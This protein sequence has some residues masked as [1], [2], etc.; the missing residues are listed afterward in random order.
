ME[1][2]N[3]L[4]TETFGKHK[5]DRQIMYTITIGGE[6]YFIGEYS[7]TKGTH[8]RGAPMLNV[9][10]SSAEVYGSRTHQGLR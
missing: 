3:A 9:S 8:E 5:Y 6:K 4:S 7:I 10:Y 2:V 1:A